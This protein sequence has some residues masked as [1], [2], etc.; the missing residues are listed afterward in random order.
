[1]SDTIKTEDWR[2][3]VGW[4]MY[5]VSS[6][7]R[8]RSLDMQVPAKGGATARRSGRILKAVRA[9]SGYLGVSLARN[10]KKIRVSIH[11]LVLFAF[12]GPPKDGHE[13]RHKNGKKSCNSL[14]NLQ[15]GSKIEN[16][17]DQVAHGTAYTRAFETYNAQRLPLAAKGAEMQRT[18]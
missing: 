18:T 15:W 7:G 13:T 10:G 17:A 8:V 9:S 2:P 3:V 1:M 12:R 5:E 6:H 14:S 11:R 4:P 16:H